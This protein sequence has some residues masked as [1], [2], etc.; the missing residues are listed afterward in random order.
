M[1]QPEFDEAR[2]FRIPAEDVRDLMT[3][4]VDER[5]RPVQVVPSD[6]DRG[7]RAEAAVPV[8]DA[9]LKNLRAETLA[10]VGEHRRCLAPEQ[11]ERRRHAELGD[12]GERP[13]VAG[14]LR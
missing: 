12:P 2:Y 1:P 13:H 6:L 10:D 9:R 3:G 11:I 7:G 5:G 4:L 14:P 8:P